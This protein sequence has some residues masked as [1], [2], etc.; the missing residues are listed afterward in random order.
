MIDSGNSYYNYG[1]FEI[2]IQNHKCNYYTVLLHEYIHYL[3]DT[4]TYFGAKLRE[5]LYSRTQNVDTFLIQGCDITCLECLDSLFKTSLPNPS[6]FCSG[7]IE[8]LRIGTI[9][10]GAKAIKENMAYLAQKYLDESFFKLYAGY[11]LVSLYIETECQF[12]QNNYLAQFAL[13]DICLM[14]EN[15]AKALI[16]IV[17]YFKG[18]EQTVSILCNEKNIHKLYEICE[19]LLLQESLLKYD[20]SINCKIGI[21]DYLCKTTLGSRKIYKILS[22][23]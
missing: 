21:N 15:P 1:N 3:Q 7:K 12:L 23:V 19:S 8:V 14:T 16:K 20:E 22:L 18:K 11:E 2:K 5:D 9:I 4:C 17:E 13:D 6:V 10:I